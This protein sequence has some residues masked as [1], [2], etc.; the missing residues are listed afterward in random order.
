VAML[1]FSGHAEFRQR[2]VL[3]TLSRRPIR[4]EEIRTGGSADAVGLC[5]FEASFLRLVE[6]LV[7]GSEIIVNE[8]GTALQYRPGMIIGGRR[9]RPACLPPIAEPLHTISLL[10]AGMSSTTVA[11]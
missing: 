8:T 5:D 3:A 9:D 7:D 6:K 10:L 4:I 11:K 1:R 2:I